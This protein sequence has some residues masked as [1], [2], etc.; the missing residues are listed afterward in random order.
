MSIPEHDAPQGAGIPPG[1]G[2]APPPEMQEDRWSSLDPL[3]EK[4]V[5][6]LPAHVAFDGWSRA[7]ITAAAA[8]AGVD[9]EA[10]RQAFP[11]GGIDAAL[12]FQ[13]R[14]DR[15]MREALAKEPLESMGM[16][17]RVTRAIRLRLEIDEEHREAVRRAATLFALPQHAAEGAGMVWRCADAV[18]SALGDGSQDVNWYTKRATLAGV[19]SS[20][21]LYWLQDESVGREASWAY[22]DR[23]IGDVMRIEKAKAAVRRNPLGKLVMGGFGRLTSGVKP[24]RRARRAP[25]LG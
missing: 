12:A 9:A 18:W 6:A 11:R 21:V 16:T 13:A 8:D 4:L 20:T 2:A 10:A 17:A 5:E 15:L 3:R 19:I 25:G 24:P 22:L 1:A 7:A 23:R 14:G